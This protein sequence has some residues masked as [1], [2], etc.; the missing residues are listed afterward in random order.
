[1]TP[2]EISEACQMCKDN[3]ENACSILMYFYTC[4]TLY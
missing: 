4:N 2:A 1:M 3:G